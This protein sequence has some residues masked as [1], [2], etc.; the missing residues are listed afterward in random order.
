MPLPFEIRKFQE[1]TRDEEAIIRNQTAKVKDRERREE[2]EKHAEFRSIWNS[3][4][5]TVE[6]AMRRKRRNANRTIWG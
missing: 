1:K 5:N 6:E 3:N 2:E 4:I